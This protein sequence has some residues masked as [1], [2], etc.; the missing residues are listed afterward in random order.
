[1]TTE[2]MQYEEAAGAELAFAKLF[3]VYQRSLNGEYNHV[4]G[5]G[6]VDVKYA[7]HPDGMLVV[8]QIKSSW[9]KS[10]EPPDAY[11]LMTGRMPEYSFRGWAT[12]E[13]VFQECNL[14]DAICPNGGPCYGIPQDR[15]RGIPV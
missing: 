7:Y 9:I 12:R 11:A 1:M 10:T 3:N 13:E 5:I 2:I 8:A 6:N 4:P 14:T 15:L